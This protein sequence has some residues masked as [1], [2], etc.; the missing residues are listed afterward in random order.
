MKETQAN[1]NSPRILTLQIPNG[2]QV[3]G[4]ADPDF[5]VEV[6]SLPRILS[7]QIKPA[8][9]RQYDAGSS[10]RVLDVKT[11]SDEAPSPRPTT[12]CAGYSPQEAV[13]LAAPATCC[14]GHSPRE[15]VLPPD[16]CQYKLSGIGRPAFS[17]VA[18]R[19]STS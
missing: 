18:V 1:P 7:G 15:A 9:I 19:S 3:G 8:P 17:A 4:K 6:V 13:L 11:R 2:P 14:A 16:L 5:K 12:G 10:L